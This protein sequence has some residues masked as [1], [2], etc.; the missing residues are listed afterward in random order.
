MIGT[1]LKYSLTFILLLLIQVTVLNN[2]NFLGWATPYLYIYF[3]LILPANT[4]KGLLF[5]LGF[6]LGFSMDVF[7]DTPGMHSI[8][9]VITAGLR[10]PILQLYFSSEEIETTSPS[11][12][13]LGLWRFMRY[14]ITLLLL[15]HFTLL[16][17]ESFALMNIWMLIGKTILC[18]SFSSLLIFSIESLKIS[19]R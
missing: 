8:A 16:L 5:T 3:I 14:A 2:F 6:L 19:S 13:S 9:T 4:P 12:F 17:V 18:V 15:H 10:Y 11:G 7:C 1:I